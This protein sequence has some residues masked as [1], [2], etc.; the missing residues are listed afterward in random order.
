MPAVSS[1]RLAGLFGSYLDCRVG[2][3]LED[4]RFLRPCQAYFRQR[5]RSVGIHAKQRR[6]TRIKDSALYPIPVRRREEA[7]FFPKRHL[8]L[9]VVLLPAQ[10]IDSRGNFSPIAHAPR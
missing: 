8:H 4:D 7:A 6:I 3:F 10:L 2:T 1:A 9:R 5:A